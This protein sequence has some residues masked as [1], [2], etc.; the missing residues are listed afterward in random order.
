MKST[1]VILYRACARRPEREREREREREGGSTLILY[2]AC[3]RRPEREREREREREKIK[4]HTVLL[5]RAR[6]RRPARERERERERRF[7]TGPVLCVQLQSLPAILTPAGWSRS[8]RLNFPS[9]KPTVMH[10]LYVSL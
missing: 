3:A 6:A 2:R 10:C 9:G 7:C 5:Y 1:I 4:V 8:E